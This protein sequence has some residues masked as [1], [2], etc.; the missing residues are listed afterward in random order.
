MRV[1]NPPRSRRATSN[2]VRNNNSNS[3]AVYRDEINRIKQILPLFKVPYTLGQIFNS[4]NQ[5]PFLKPDGKIK[6]PPNCFMFFR[7]ITNILIKNT[8]M[9]AVDKLFFKNLDQPLLSQILGALWNSFTLSEQSYYRELYGEVTKLHKSLHPDWKYKPK[10]SKAIFKVVKFDSHDQQEPQYQD[11]EIS[12]AISEVTPQIEV[13]PQ[14][15]VTPTDIDLSTFY[16]FY[17]QQ[18]PFQYV[19]FL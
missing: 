14:T 5:S 12:S 18:Q 6:R 7:Q 15:E 2:S 10:R 3:V 17:G 9:S 11:Q 1:T 4:E 16:L 13:T 19:N 8:E